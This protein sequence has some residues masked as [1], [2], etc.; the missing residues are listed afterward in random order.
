MEEEIKNKEKKII[1]ID[2]KK[3]KKEAFMIEESHPAIGRILII[4][5]EKY[6]IMNE[7]TPGAHRT[8]TFIASLNERDEEAIEEYDN[9]LEELSE[10]LVN[11]V[12]IKKLIK[13]NMKSKPFEEIKTGLFILK[14]QEDGEEVEEE[15]HKG[16]YNY[17][18]H[19]KNHTFDFLSGDDISHGVLF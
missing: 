2:G 8:G 18:A 16:C 10:R 6:K 12:D 13:E 14:A 19:Y 9:A 3:Y 1:K 17:K 4:D 15:H 5:G 7:A 11:K